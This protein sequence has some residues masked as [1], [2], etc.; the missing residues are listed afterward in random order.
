MV[1]VVAVTST[2][3]T[4]LRKKKKKKKVGSGEDFILFV[5]MDCGSYCKLKSNQTEKIK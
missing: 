1:V 2:I 5:F 4:E 3:R